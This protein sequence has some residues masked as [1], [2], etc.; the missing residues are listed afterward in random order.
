[1]TPEP[2]DR[3]DS[4]EQDTAVG[5]DAETYIAPDEP[6]GVHAHGITTAQQRQGETFVDRERHTQPEDLDNPGWD[7]T[8]S[9]QLVQPG[10][11]DIDVSD[12]ESN[13]VALD[14]GQIDGDISAEE[15]AMHTIDEP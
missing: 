8:R 2:V 11:E 14:A 4:E 1:M 12:D 7:A 13:T 15:A 5:D 10:D 6:F 3:F 9:G